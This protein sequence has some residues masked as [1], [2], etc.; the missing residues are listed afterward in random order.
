[1]LV[2]ELGD[3][4]E[5][6]HDAAGRITTVSAT[7]WDWWDEEQ[8]RRAAEAAAGSGASWSRVG[9]ESPPRPRYSERRTVLR[10]RR[11]GR[12]RLE[13]QPDAASGQP[14]T[15]HVC[16]GTREWTYVPERR[17]AWVQPAGASRAADDLLDPAW[18][19]ADFLLTVAGR[20][21]HD[22]RAAIEL[23]GR[24]RPATPGARFLTRAHPGAEAIRAVVD[25][26]SGLLLELTS[27]FQG[28]PLARR[29]LGDLALGLP[30]DP[31]WFRFEPPP[32]IRVEDV[33][34]HHPGL[35]LR[36]RPRPWRPR[37]RRVATYLRRRRRR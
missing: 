28:E 12:Y 37:P 13:A 2:S 18:L 11:P 26:D 35:N 31:T 22:G 17:E 20:L 36:W 19:P 27:L 14:Y 1:M 29:S 8:S 21:R 23:R 10:Y 33:Q 24:L 3:V 9:G 32:G 6:L 7:L 15:L 25:Q 16:D 30:I 34:A 4:L 5:L